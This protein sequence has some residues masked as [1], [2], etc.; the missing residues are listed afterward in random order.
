M[1]DYLRDGGISEEKI[2]TVWAPA[3]LDLGASTPEEIALSV[4]SQMVALRRGGS[5]S[6]L[7]LQEPGPPQG[8]LVTDA[9]IRQCETDIP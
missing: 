9:I 5:L 6:R 3:G 7:Y 2:A 8:S 1:L 4:I